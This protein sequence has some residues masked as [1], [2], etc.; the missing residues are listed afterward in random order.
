M[1]DKLPTS[2]LEVASSLDG[3]LDYV[4]YQCNDAE[5]HTYLEDLDEAEAAILAAL[6]DFRSLKQ[7]ARRAG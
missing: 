5:R 3:L 4:W 7:A 1:T 6:Q 2:L